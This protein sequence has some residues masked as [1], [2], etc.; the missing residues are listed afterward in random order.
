MEPVT[1]LPNKY[2][3]GKYLKNKKGIRKRDPEAKI[4]PPSETLQKYITYLQEN[5]AEMNKLEY[6]EFK[7]KN[8]LT[9]P[10]LLAKEKILT[11]ETIVRIPRKL[12]LSTR[13]AYF[14][15]VRKVF[16]DNPEFFSPCLTNSWEDRMLLVFL[17][18]EHQKGTDSEWF[19]LLS[20]LPKDIDY[21]VFWND[22]ELNLLEDKT[23]FCL[24]K[25]RRKL[26]DQEE[27]YIL[28][29]GKKYPGL[30]DPEVFVPENVR[31][32]YTHLITRCFGKYLEYVEMIP[33]AELFNHDCTDVYYDLEYYENNP[34]KPADY[35]METPKEI[36]EEIIANYETSDGSYNSED[37]EFDS[38]YE[39]DN[40]KNETKELYS[41]Q[42]IKNDDSMFSS[43]VHSNLKEVEE[44]LMDNFDWA[45]GF[46]LF[47]VRNI[48]EEAL[49]IVKNY[50][51]GK[52]SLNSAKNMFK[53]V[54]NSMLLF[55]DK[56]R[57][58][59]TEAYDIS[60]EEIVIKQKKI[61]QKREAE[62]NK[63][64]RKKEDF[65]ELFQPDEKWKDDT[66][67]N[68]VMKASSH[69]Q[70][71]KGS[72]VYFCYGRLSNRLMLM[73]Y[74]LALEYNKYEHIHFKVPYMSYFKK[75]PWILE[76]VKEFGLSKYMRFKLKR[77]QVNESLI[78]F[79]KGLT[80][81]K[82]YDD[83]ALVEPTN[84]DAEI[85]GVEKAC[86]LLEDF[87]ESFSKT[88]EEYKK[89]RDD[90]QTDYHK[91]FAAV[92][93]LERQRLLTFHIKALNV[94]REILVRMSEGEAFEKATARVEEFESD[95]EC[96]RNR[97]FLEKYLNR[98]K[99]TLKE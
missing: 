11:D 67:D 87:L 70:F 50:E 20:N 22:E 77:T 30:L 9:Y 44:F 28:D 61:A 10:G 15:D 81:S 38:D 82:R 69:D 52:T 84:I 90:P 95:E 85:K 72:Q 76:K 58:F 3:V 31:W 56:V 46:S 2:T 42:T 16:L 66:F 26:Y 12:L 68:F 89:I 98:I 25:R 1:K 41:F 73:R 27:S 24:A 74:G 32:I 33:F 6:A 13:K 37:F 43:A 45:D 7:L 78:N 51:S 34:H 5:G 4:I 96:Y 71:E 80:F 99:K 94:L 49:S 14:S 88:P 36:D 57:A 17:L 19:Y 54:N 93:C 18:Y 92:F 62:Q 60:E 40:D 35:E 47:F 79:G 21:A 48:Y 23:I 91:Y 8:G 39:Y 29:L 97:F 55:K 75:T 59:Y 83:Q 53:V 64:E 86:D 63:K 65:K